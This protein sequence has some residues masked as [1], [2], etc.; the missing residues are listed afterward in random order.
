MTAFQER[1]G[2]V[3]LQWMTGANTVVYRLS[4]GRTA[5]HLPGGASICLLTTRGRR[6]GRARTV[7]LLYIAHGDDEIVVVASH[8][9][10]SHHPAWYLNLRDDPRATVA[11]GSRRRDMTARPA[12]AAERAEIWPALT[13]VYPHFDA[14]QQ[15]TVRRIP[16]L[17]LSSLDPPDP[18][19]THRGRR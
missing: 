3:A 14:Y 12:T 9:G 1:V 17:I 19:R 2:R 18:R 8:G 10:M 16:V 7:P 15:R 13:A 11:V 4:N 5:G 6:T